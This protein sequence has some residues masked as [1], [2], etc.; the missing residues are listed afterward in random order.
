MNIQAKDLASMAT[1]LIYFLVTV[2]KL[3][4]LM[5][6]FLSVLFYKLFHVTWLLVSG[7]V[8]VAQ[9]VPSLMQLLLG[10]TVASMALACIYGLCTLYFSGSV[11]LKRAN[12]YKWYCCWI[13]FFGRIY[14]RYFC[15]NKDWK[16]TWCFSWTSRPSKCPLGF[17]EL[18]TC[19]YLQLCCFKNV[20]VDTILPKKK[21]LTCTVMNNFKL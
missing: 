18:C 4:H 20:V 5:L 14:A 19:W 1:L 13:D 2:L 7:P 21:Q 11:P 12:G 15:W 9:A 6:E 3:I 8:S 10:R 17:C 16:A